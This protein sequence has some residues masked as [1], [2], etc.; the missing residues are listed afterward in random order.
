MANTCLTNKVSFWDGCGT[1]PEKL[2]LNDLPGF[3]LDFAEY[4]TEADKQTGTDVLNA[5]I[6]LGAEK[7]EDDVRSFVQ[8]NAVIVDSFSNQTLGIIQDNKKVKTGEANTLKG[9]RLDLSRAPFFSLYIN[10]ISFFPVSGGS[11]TAKIFNLLTGAE[12]DAFPITYVANEVNVITVD[13]EY[14]FQGQPIDVI[15]VIESVDCY[16]V[17]LWD[18]AACLACEGKMMN[19]HLF[20]NSIKINSGAQKISNNVKSE[21]HTGGL[22][23]NYSLRCDIADYVCGL[24]IGLMRAAWYA[25]GINVMNEII[26]SQRLNNLTTVGKDDAIALKDL[27]TAEYNTIMGRTVETAKLPNNP[28]FFCNQSVKSYNAIP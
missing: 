23:V 5:A 4:I 20:A 10:T 6:R 15:I 28:C 21:T 19:P 8:P 12:L 16:T 9:I 26:F 1:R 13:K 25:A 14:R 27:Y 3:R 22:W 7:V 18:R 17:Q 2:L 11:G 24:S